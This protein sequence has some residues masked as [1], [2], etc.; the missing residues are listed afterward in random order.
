MRH[1]LTDD[2]SALGPPT[3]LLSLSSGYLERLDITDQL[4]ETWFHGLEA[5]DEDYEI[6]LLLA[7]MTNVEHLE[8]TM[9]NYKSFMRPELLL[10]FPRILGDNSFLQHLHSIR[11]RAADHDF[12]D[13]EYRPEFEPYHGY[14]SSFFLPL[15]TLP[16]LRSAE[17]KD[18]FDMLDSI[19]EYTDLVQDHHLMVI[20]SYQMVSYPNPS[21]RSVITT[22]CVPLRVT[23]QAVL[24]LAT[25]RAPDEFLPRQL[26]VLHFTNCD[27]LVIPHLEQLISNTSNTMSKFEK[28]RIDRW[29][30]KIAWRYQQDD[31]NPAFGH[32]GG[33]VTDHKF[34]ANTRCL[35][36]C[37]DWIPSLSYRRV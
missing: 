26:E 31:E 23:S 13:F 22:H 35:R 2:L 18:A 20:R 1:F 7:L 6:A 36:G 9:P 5:V 10:E 33:K 32:R 21:S 34:E 8:I 4:R 16:S 30:L 11:V 3:E 12:Y 14:P 37:R 15:L 28:I 19:V 29:N 24:D 27:E 17:I 25:S